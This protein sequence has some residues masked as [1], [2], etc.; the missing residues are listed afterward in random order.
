MFKDKS[1]KKFEIKRVFFISQYFPPDYAPTGNLIEQLINSL[2]YREIIVYTGIP[3]YAK[4]NKEFESFQ[5]KNNISISRSSFSDILPKKF[6]GRIINSFLFTL[7]TFFKLIIN[8]KKEDLI[9]LTSEPPFVPSLFWIVYL[10]KRNKFIL[11]IFDIYPD[12][13]CAIGLIRKRK[14]VYQI[15]K[16]LNR[17]SFHFTKEIV[18]LNKEMK[19]KILNDYQISPDKINIIPPWVD[20][21]QIKPIINSK[22]WF[23]DKHQLRDKFIVLYSG[24]QGRG[25][26]FDTILDAASLL[27]EDIEIVFLFIGGG[28]QNNYL[29]EEI[30]RLKLGNCKFL[31][32]QSF[33]TLPYALSSA[34]IGLVTIKKELEGVI[35][36]SKIF[37]YFATSTAVG[38]I[39]PQSSYL[40]EIVENKNCGKWFSNYD[41]LSLANWIRFS[42]SNRAKLNEMGENGKLFLLE[43]AT[44][45]KSIAKYINLF[46]KYKIQE[47]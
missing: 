41:S 7:R 30:Y 39:S 28:N 16:S 22:N 34:D 45:E 13:L 47:I 9:I 32:Y 33:E 44:L 46:N 43:N 10:F 21:K 36:P 12:L 27:R 15:W 6:Q 4:D 17:L 29:H 1:K 31:P 23:I 3:G 5:K 35:A 8:L 25:H 14:I 18:V 40:K 24:N 2:N 42:K 37:S 20:S 11:I 26:D 38:V 19:N